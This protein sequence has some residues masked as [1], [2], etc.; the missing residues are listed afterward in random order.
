MVKLNL[1]T[2]Y[3]LREH[4]SLSCTVGLEHSH[5]CGP[6]EAPS[7]CGDILAPEVLSFIATD[8]STPSLLTD[9]LC[10]E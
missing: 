4:D 3:N 10:V 2:H 6:M 5:H 8:E 1:V 7:V 9:T